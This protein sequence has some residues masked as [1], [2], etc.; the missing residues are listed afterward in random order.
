MIDPEVDFYLGTN[1]GSS[2]KFESHC[3]TVLTFSLFEICINE[4]QKRSAHKKSGMT[5][6]NSL[7][8]ERERE[9]LKWMTVKPSCRYS[10]SSLSNPFR[11][12]FCLPTRLPNNVVR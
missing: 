4:N 7:A 2:G 5:L 12:L 3:S 9:R 10:E 6:T 11:F 1:N 8:T